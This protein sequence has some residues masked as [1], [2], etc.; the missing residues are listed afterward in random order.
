[1]G[2]NISKGFLL[3]LVGLFAYLSLLLVLP[4][5]QYVLGA[6]LIAYVLYPL[7]QR[8]EERVAPP[9]AAF[10][11][12]G[13]AVAGF[14]VPLVVIVA[15]IASD[16]RRLLEQVNTDSIQLGELERAIEEQTGQSVDLPSAL[17]DAAQN[18]GTMVLESSTEWFSAITH[19]LIGLGLAIFL[20]YYLL[21][22]GSDLLRWMRELTPL[23]DDVQDDFYQ[24][25]DE[26]MWAVLAGHVMIAII[27]GT[28]A[29]LGLLATGVPNAAFW[30]AIMIV[31]S[32]IP[33]IGS[34]MVWGPAVI[35]LFLIE[36]PLLAVALFVYSMIVVGLSDDYLRPILVDRYAELNPAVIIL[37]VLGGVYAFGV[38]GLFYGPVVLGALIAVLDVMNDHYDRLED[39]PGMR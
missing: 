37:G 31:L 33:L 27:Q 2:V 28:I 6:I 17:A 32:L 10:A 29:G 9:I 11:L 25:L 13:L 36:E 35:Y 38:M 8:L 19:T 20:L 16:A 30:T 1:M 15:A 24:E 14:V 4:F 34:F 18:V 39:E 26:V 22:D 3:V 7:Q 12:V 5:S 21:K 23:P